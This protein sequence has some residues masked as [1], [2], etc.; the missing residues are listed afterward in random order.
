VQLEDSRET[1]TFAEGAAASDVACFLM[2][3]LGP[4]NEAARTLP[5]VIRLPSTGQTIELVS[6]ILV[7]EGEVLRIESPLTAPATVTLHSHRLRVE[8][9]GEL[10]LYALT[11]AD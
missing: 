9:G 2:L 7:R 5:I 3:R 11:L 1:I 10:E 6:D 4:H 8:T